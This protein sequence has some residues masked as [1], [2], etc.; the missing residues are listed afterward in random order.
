MI[1]FNNKTLPEWI[2]VTG[3]SFETLNISILE[4]EAK[5][6]VG[7]IDAGV[8]RGGITI[9]LSVF[10]EPVEGMNLL[11]QSDI[12]KA[13]L[14]GDNWKVSQLILLEQPNKFYNARVSNMSE[15]TDNFTHGT[16]TISFYCAN[17]KKYDLV[18]TT[19]NS[20]TGKTVINYTG[21]ETTP[22]LVDITISKA[23][24][25]L[26]LRHTESGKTVTVLGDFTIGQKVTI[27]TDNRNVLIDG[28]G[29]KEK[30]AFSSNWMYLQPGTNTLTC[31]N[32][33]DIK[34]EY[35]TKYRQ[36]Y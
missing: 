3:V 25:N 7:N 26:E 23:V 14:I 18:E 12:L 8:E 34:N 15:I 33:T 5:R 17:P 2:S 10:I 6:R 21:L 20:T 22:V 4:H 16:A 11:D 19:K 31:T 27:D 29:S 28:K 30:L 9:D 24:T 1:K 13:F 35:T 32:A 36:A